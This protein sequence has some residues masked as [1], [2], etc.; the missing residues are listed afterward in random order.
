MAEPPLDG[1]VQLSWTPLPF[2]GEAERV[3]A[4]GTVTVGAACGVAD[5]VGTSDPEAVVDTPVD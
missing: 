4:P 5:A 2:A 3:G 1:T